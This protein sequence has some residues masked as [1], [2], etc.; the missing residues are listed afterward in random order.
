MAISLLATLLFCG[1]VLLL[2][3]ALIYFFNHTTRNRFYKPF[4]RPRGDIN[5]PQVFLDGSAGNP[6]ESLR[7]GER[8]EE[9]MQTA[10]PRQPHKRQRYP[11]ETRATKAK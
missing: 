11:W 1:L 5:W 7:A 8:F 6:K 4:S 2:F 10:Q 9:L 3:G